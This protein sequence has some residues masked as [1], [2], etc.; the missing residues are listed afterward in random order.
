[1]K[2]RSMKIIRMNLLRNR[3]ILRHLWVVLLESSAYNYL[4]VFNF[5][6]NLRKLINSFSYTRNPHLTIEITFYFPCG[7]TLITVKC[8]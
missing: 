7:F 8:I 6:C 3:D 5:L 1:M 4:R 2:G